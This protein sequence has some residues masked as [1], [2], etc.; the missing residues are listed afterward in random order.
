MTAVTVH[1]TPEDAA[2]LLELAALHAEGVGAMLGHVIRRE[3]SKA[4]YAV[5]TAVALR[6]QALSTPGWRGTGPVG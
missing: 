1:L 5:D 3:L 2:A 6:A 4:R